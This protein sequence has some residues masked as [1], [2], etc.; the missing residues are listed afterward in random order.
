ML[1]ELNDAI[2]AVGY[3]P[4]HHIGIGKVTRFSTNNK[5][6]DR[7][8]WVLVF[9]DGK[10]AVFGCWRSGEQHQW[11]AHRDYMPSITEQEAMRQ[12]F[13]EA[14]RKAT[15]QRDEDYA[16]AA[17]EAKSLFDAAVVVKE[18]DY[19]TDKGIN[20]NMAK[21][22]GGKLLIPVYDELG[23]IQS[24]QSIFS[25]GAKRFHAGGK[26][27]GGHCWIKNTIR[28]EAYCYLR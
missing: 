19:L 28:Q 5:Q 24:L 21:V 7:S 8:G 25:D 14:K 20:P 18:H 16:V 23:N 22:F 13:E 3:T 27:Q 9:D 10:G 12:Q 15:L 4:P 17:R 11:Q 6:S 26:M 1:N 2:K